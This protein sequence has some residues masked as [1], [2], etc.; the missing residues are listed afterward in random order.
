[1]S[2]SH[3]R[4]YRAGPALL[5]VIAASALALGQAAPAGASP[6]SASAKPRV[7]FKFVSNRIGSTQHPVIKYTSAHLPA[8]TKLELQ[9]QFGTAHV[10]KNVIALKGSSGK[11]TA[12]KVQMGRYRYRIRAYRRTKTVVFSPNGILYSY[13]RVPLSNICNDGNSNSSVSMNGTNCSTSTVQVGNSVFVYLI[14]DFPPGQPNYDQ[15]I[16]FGTNTSCRTISFQFSL[17]NNASNGSDTASIKLVQTAS[18]AQSKSVGTG[19][20]ANALFKLDGGPWD[21]DLS[22]SHFDAEYVN[23][24]ASC[25]TPGGLR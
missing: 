16:T 24:S 13:G 9:R 7:S 1:M 15:D 8:G 12:P 11:A 18:D 17:D 21:L 6:T 10:W 2:L 4:T 20:I 23:G 19:Q 25:W 22:D 14:R 3:K 5:A